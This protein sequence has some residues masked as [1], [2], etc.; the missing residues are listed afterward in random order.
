MTLK[1]FRSV[2]VSGNAPGQP[3]GDAMNE[4]RS[5]L[6]NHKIQPA[7]FRSDPSAPGSAAFEIR[8][9]RE[10]E[11]RLFERT[12]TPPRRDRSRPVWKPGAA[13]LKRARRQRNPGKIVLSL[14][15]RL[16]L[17]SMVPMT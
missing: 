6:D 10:D 15:E 4:I 11:A 3:L 13:G 16:S 5:W 14:A 12:F 7:E 2:S 8:F 17:T 1:I 9:Q